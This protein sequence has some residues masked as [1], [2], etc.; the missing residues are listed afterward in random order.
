MPSCTFL[1][2]LIQIFFHSAGTE[3]P[4]LE[5]SFNFFMN[6]NS[7]KNQEVANQSSDGSFL[8]GGSFSEKN[9]R[10]ESNDFFDIG[11]IVSS[12]DNTMGAGDESNGSFIFWNFWLS[13]LIFSH[14]VGHHFHCH[15]NYV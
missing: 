11:D 4:K 2:N 6:D 10:K 15:L 1:W 13:S 12:N 14:W 9:N 7:G 8:A 5:D 3:S